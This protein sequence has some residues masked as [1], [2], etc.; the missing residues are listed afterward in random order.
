MLLQKP[1]NA[2]DI[3]DGPINFGMTHRQL[4]ILIGRNASKSV[5]YFT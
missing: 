5:I 1:I 2:A 4:C 3:S